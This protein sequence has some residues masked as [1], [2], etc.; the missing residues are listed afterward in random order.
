MS[1]EYP[2]SIHI[3]QQFSTQRNKKTKVVKLDLCKAIWSVGL[4]I[5]YRQNSMSVEPV[6]QF[7]IVYN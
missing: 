2:L 5:K 1:K 3:N 7:K 6:F 4:E